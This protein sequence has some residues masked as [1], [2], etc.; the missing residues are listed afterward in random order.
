MFGMFE[1]NHCHM[2][3]L[4]FS[5]YWCS[6]SLSSINFSSNSMYSSI[7]LSYISLL[8]WF[9]C[10]ILVDNA[11]C[12]R[13]AIAIQLACGDLRCYHGSWSLCGAPQYHRPDCNCG[14]TVSL[15][16]F[17]L[18]FAVLWFI[19]VFYSLLIS[20]IFM[21]IYIVYIHAYS[22]YTHTVIL[23]WL[24]TV[25]V[26]CWSSGSCIQLQLQWPQTKSSHS[27]TFPLRIWSALN[28]HC[29]YFHN[30]FA[31]LWLFLLEKDVRHY[32]F[33]LLYICFWHRNCFVIFTKIIIFVIF[34]V[35]LYCVSAL[36]LSQVIRMYIY[37]IQNSL[38]SI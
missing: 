15:P 35:N 24:D 23:F 3:N 38:Q 14:G 2:I 36:A 19:V 16:I 20:I 26:W 22:T 29:S 6:S 7:F 9:L 34:C 28:R 21:S 32:L 10:G 30:I 13:E 25:L 11:A 5:I 33:L 4:W 8:R 17:F 18:E 27:F 12:Q 37:S 1:R 31:Q